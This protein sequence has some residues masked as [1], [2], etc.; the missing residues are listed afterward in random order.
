MRSRASVIALLLASAILTH[1]AA[2]RASSDYSI[3]WFVIGAGGGVSTADAYTLRGV[4]GQPLAHAPTTSGQYTIT[5]GFLAIPPAP[6]L[7]PCPGD[8]NAD[9]VVNFADLNAVLSAFGQTGQGIPGDVNNDGT[10][11]FAD[12]NLVLSVFGAACP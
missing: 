4:I 1:G 2:S 11:N 10:V 12:L 6:P 9:G 3:D 5:G 7:P 8:T